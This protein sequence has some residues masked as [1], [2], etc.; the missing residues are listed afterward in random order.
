MSG[1]FQL[2]AH[3]FSSSGLRS[4][5]IKDNEW[6]AFN[7]NWDVE[8]TGREITIF[9]APKHITLRLV[10]DPPRGIVIEALDMYVYGYRFKGG[11]NELLMQAPNGGWTSFTGCL[12][13][14]VEEG[15]YIGS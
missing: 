9:D 15:I 3:F 5:F 8:I 2:T 6:F 7:S 10:T 12:M 4:L 14:G 1:P 13:D 11:P